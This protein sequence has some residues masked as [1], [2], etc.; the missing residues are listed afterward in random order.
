M[1]LAKAYQQT[2]GIKP[3]EVD[4]QNNITT[5][6][7]W[8]QLLNKVKGRFKVTC[9]SA[10]SKDYILNCLLLEGVFCIT[11]TTIGIVPL[12]CRPTGVNV[13]SRP[14]KVLISNPILGTL[15]RTMGVDC[16]IVYLYD[17][18]YFRTIDLMLNI[19]AQKLAS[20]D[21]AIDV[22]LLNTKAAFMFNAENTKQAEEAKLVYDKI[23]R[24]EPAVFTKL[25]TGIDNNGLEVVTLP[26]KNNYVADMIQEEKRQIINEFLTEIGINNTNLSKRE[27]MITDEVNANDEEIENNISYIKENLKDCV[28]RV[29]K[30]FPSIEFNIELKE[31]RNNESYQF[32]G[33]LQPTRE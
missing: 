21:S 13:F 29:N 7:Y 14:Y 20:C 12:L 31:Y 8:E 2:Y 16:E 27:R 4:G 23:A 15:E 10:W 3:N 9:N 17:D 11:D 6:Y 33:D 32:N 5:T 28:E 30:M 26:V 22:N 19:Y 24:G 1:S 25:K 18:K